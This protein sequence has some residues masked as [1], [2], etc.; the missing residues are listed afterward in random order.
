MFKLDV[1]HF[2]KIWEIWHWGRLSR[3]HTA[4]SKLLD[5]PNVSDF[6]GIPLDPYPGPCWIRTRVSGWNLVTIVSKLGSFTYLGDVSNLI[7]YIG[8][9]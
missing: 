6:P 4:F 9:D 8:V 2:G 3:G 7:T 1:L 5:F